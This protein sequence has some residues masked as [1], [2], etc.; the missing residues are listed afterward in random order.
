[1]TVKEQLDNRE[2][3]W[4]IRVAA[5]MGIINERTAKHADLARDS[6]NLIH[7][8]KLRREERQ[9]TQKDALSALTAVQHVIEEFEARH[10]AG[11]PI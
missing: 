6:R 7:P 4:Y 9:C 8:G 3:G 1:M 11:K 2:L 5:E 10:G